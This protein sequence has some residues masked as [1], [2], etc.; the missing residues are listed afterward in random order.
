MVEGKRGHEVN[1][2]ESKN[3]KKVKIVKEEDLKE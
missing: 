3:A 2:V 1:A